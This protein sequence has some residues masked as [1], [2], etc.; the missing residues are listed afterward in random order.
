LI[1]PAT[2]LVG[3]YRSGAENAIYPSRLESAEGYFLTIDAMRFFAAAYV[4]NQHDTYD[5]RASPL[6]APDHTALPAA[7]VCTAEFDP[8]RDEGEA[9]ARRL[10]HAAV[11]VDYFREPG[12]IHGYF[13]MGAASPAADAARQR[14]C[15]AFKRLLDPSGT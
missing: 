2:D 1:Y 5:P 10:E 13:G 3:S 7:V 9:Y 11:R 14:A 6:R 8:L 4:P 12:M 15:A